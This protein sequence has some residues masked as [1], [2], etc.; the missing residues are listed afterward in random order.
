MEFNIN[1]S[2]QIVESNSEANG[3]VCEEDFNENI[4]DSLVNTN[5]NEDK[6]DGNINEDDYE[7]KKEDDSKSSAA[8]VATVAE[9]PLTNTFESKVDWNVISLSSIWIFLTLTFFGIFF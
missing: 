2:N 3:N 7:S 4:S 8:S 1:P 6:Y 5:Y 9:T